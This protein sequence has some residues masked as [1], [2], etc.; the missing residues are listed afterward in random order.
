[1]KNIIET[2]RTNLFEP[3]DTITMRFT[4]E[5]DVTVAQVITAFDEVVAAHET[6]CSSIKLDDKGE[7]WYEPCTCNMNHMVED[8]RD[9]ETIFYEQSRILFKIDKGELMRGFVIC[10]DHVLE[11]LI[12]AN[13][14]AGDGKSIVHFIGQLMDA[15]LGN[16]PSCFKPLK[17]IYVKDLPKEAKL[18]FGVRKFVEY[19]NR[20][21]D[22][23]GITYTMEDRAKV[24]STYWSK[25]RTRMVT[26][27]FTKDEVRHL[28]DKCHKG[29]YSLTS[30][31]ICA[32]IR[33]LN[34]K[35]CA[36]LAVDGRFAPCDNMGNLT[37]GTAID[38]RYRDSKSFDE[39]ARA[40]NKVLKS[41]LEDVASKYFVLNFMGSLRVSL[42]DAMYMSINGCT[43]NKVVASLAKTCS[44]SGK[45]REFSITNLT[46]LDIPS[47]YGNLHIKDF[48][49][50][51]PH[52]S[53]GDRLIGLAT[54]DGEMIVSFQVMEPVEE[55]DGVATEEFNL[56]NEII[57]ELK[58]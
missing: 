19:T 35:A 41:K 55:A 5:G 50:V 13:H 6:L 47:Q 39:N 7:A 26:E 21:W 58:R 45:K 8:S 2:E 29:G 30:A 24:H 27:H 46:V 51:P 3:N 28:L 31:L 36:G 23:Q 56:F 12:M 10:R 38:Y 32:S 49:F 4:I 20:R 34:R 14:F 1:M 9:W 18:K 17:T 43:N 16:K 37:T 57:K 52:I 25:N 40:I 22:K 11:V 33:T 42:I 54:L 48:T 53:Y 15:L 44:Y